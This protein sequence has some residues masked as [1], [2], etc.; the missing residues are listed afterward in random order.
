MFR[1]LLFAL[2]ALALVLVL[3]SPGQAHARPSRGGFHHGMHGGM[4]PGFRG[5]IMAPRFVPRR[6]DRFEDRLERRFPRG[7]FDRFGGRLQSGF[8]SPFQGG[9]MPGLP[10]MMPFTFSGQ[11]P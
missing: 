6:A 3:G 7:R 1:R 2:G 10:R 5:P 9:F 4:S 11:L 8:P